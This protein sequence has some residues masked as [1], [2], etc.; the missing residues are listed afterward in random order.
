[1]FDFFRV[2][3]YALRG[4]LKQT[5][6]LRTGYWAYIAVSWL[7]VCLLAYC[8]WVSLGFYGSWL[9]E[10][11]LASSL[12]KVITLTLALTIYC[13]MRFTSGWLIRLCRGESQLLKRHGWWLGASGLILAGL[14]A[15]DIY[16][17]L[18]GARYLSQLSASPAPKL[19]LNETPTNQHSIQ[20]WRHQKDSIL[21]RYRSGGKLY[22]GP[23]PISRHS[24]ATFE[25][26]KM[27]I[28][29]LDRQI[30]REEDLQGEL[31][32]LTVSNH[33]M[34]VQRHESQ[35][36]V[37]HE[38]HRSAIQIIYVMIFVV[39]FFTSGYS[40]AVLR[41]VENRP[42]LEVE[43]IEAEIVN[44]KKEVKALVDQEISDMQK[45]H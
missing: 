5:T 34:E 42:T 45:L 2:S 6:L 12:A 17:N 9:G 20:V 38:A 18:H 21:D 36:E 25:K 3:A 15:T 4:R 32:T 44:L 24:V 14:V 43:A 27:W 35:I 8:A 28:E 22:F 10:V 1:M 33:Q 11:P 40:Q 13:L 19:S 41:Y 37:R 29:H 31:R 39:S 26:D 30:R 7:S 23:H 16:A